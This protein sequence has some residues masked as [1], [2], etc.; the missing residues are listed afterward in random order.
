M[1]ESKRLLIVAD[2]S[3]CAGVRQCVLSDPDV[4]AHDELNIVKV[5]HVE[6]DDH[7]ELAEAISVCP[8]AS[9]SAFDVE[10]GEM[11]YP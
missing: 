5:L 3:T 7:P 1:T 6:V 9:L 10:T 4:F 11:V 8:T 2:T